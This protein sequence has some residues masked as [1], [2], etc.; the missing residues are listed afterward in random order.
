MGN[1]RKDQRTIY[2]PSGKEKESPWGH[3]WN[4]SPEK[5]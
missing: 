3:T 2:L 4:V 5:S 1:V